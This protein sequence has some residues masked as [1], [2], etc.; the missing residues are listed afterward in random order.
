MPGRSKA[1]R[2]QLHQ[3]AHARRFRLRH[4]AAIG[5]NAVIAAALVIQV[6][7][8]PA[9]GFFDQPKL[10]HLVNGAVEHAGSEFEPAAGAL[11]DFAP[12][13][14]AMA[15]AVS[16]REKDMEDGRRERSQVG[17]GWFVSGWHTS[18]KLDLVWIGPAALSRDECTIAQ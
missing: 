3:L 2:G 17:R 5:G 10:E 12:Q 8:G 16:E 15:F 13:R 11:R 14:V 18:P 4:L 6:R 7:I 9:I 1:R